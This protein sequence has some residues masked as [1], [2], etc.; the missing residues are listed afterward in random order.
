MIIIYIYKESYLGCDRCDAKN[1]VISG[2]NSWKK[3]EKSVTPCHTLSK[4]C[5]IE[6]PL[7]IPIYIIIWTP[8]I[9]SFFRFNTYTYSKTCIL[10]FFH[11]RLYIF[12]SLFFLFLILA[13]IKCYLVFL[14][15]LVLTLEHLL[16]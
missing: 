5:S 13:I 7:F 8:S 14:L 11:H 16:T 1:E 3:F 9:D 2:N 10:Q 12:F 15:I 6:H 4:S